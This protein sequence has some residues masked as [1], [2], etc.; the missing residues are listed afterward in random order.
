[1]CY[2]RAASATL[3]TALQTLRVSTVLEERYGTMPHQLVEILT[4]LL[5][6]QPMPYSVS[7]L[8]RLLPFLVVVVL[9]VL[10]LVWAQRSVL[11]RTAGFQQVAARL[12]FFY[13][14]PGEGLLVE[15]LA[16]FQ[17]VAQGKDGRISNMLQG[18]S[19]LADVSVFDYS[20][21]TGAGKRAQ[22][23]RQS[24]IC[25]QSKASSWPAF[26]LR[27]AGPFH[28]FTEGVGYR[29]LDRTV[30]PLLPESHVL[31]GDDEAAVLALFGVMQWKAITSQARGSLEARGGRFLYYRQRQRIKPDQLEQFLSEGLEMFAM[32]E[33]SADGNL[34]PH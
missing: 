18:K 2:N 10:G 11:R 34:G 17:L 7:A 9:I 29:Q 30:I 15:D 3:G 16:G 14:E 32:F 23:H 19:P 28:R 5:G 26:A 31:C 8:F 6:Q 20:Y 24:V 21:V 33:K 1:M 12:G 4:P 25:F 27:P 22:T 13:V